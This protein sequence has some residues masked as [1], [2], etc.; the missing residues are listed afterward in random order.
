MRQGTKKRRLSILVLLAAAASLGLSACG[1]GDASIPAEKAFALS[2]SALSGSDRY[3]FNGEVSVVGPGGM[4]ADKSRFSGEVTGH[5]NLNLKWSGG[6]KLGSGSMAKPVSY[7]P[8]QLLEAIGNRSAKVA[9]AGPPDPAGNVLLRISLSEEAARRRIAD[10]LRTD[11][12]KIRSDT[13]KRK[14]TAAERTR[15]ERMLS[16]ASRQMESAL[17][18]LKVNTV[19]LWKTD[20]KTWFPRQMTERTELSYQWQG[21][22][23]R[24]ERISVTNFLRSDRN[25]TMVTD[26]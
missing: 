15:A 19:C 9:Y 24:E 21:Q 4:I 8:L 13:E 23:R 16:Q 22:A 20:P 14:L 7:Q 2:A 5:G 25:G 10:A 3:G 12:A 26:S 6:Q 1:G 18:T 17:A 11:L